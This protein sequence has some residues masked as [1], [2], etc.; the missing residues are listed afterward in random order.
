MKKFKPP[1]IEWEEIGPTQAAEYLKKNVTNRNVRKGTVTSYARD[2]KADKWIPTHQGIA[3]NDRGELIDGQHRLHAIIEAGVSVRMLVTRGI[4]SEQGDMRT[5][6]AV[7]RGAVRSVADQLHLQHGFRNAAQLAGCGTVIV[8]LTLQDRIGRVSVPQMLSVLEIYSRHIDPIILAFNNAH[9]LKMR[10]ALLC[11]SL[12][13]ARAVAPQRVDDFTQ[14]ICTGAGLEID[15]PALA[16]RNYFLTQKASSGDQRKFFALFVLNCARCFVLGEPA[17]KSNFTRAGFI[18]F[19]ERQKENLSKLAAVF[20][21]SKA[22]L[23]DD[24]GGSPAARA[25]SKTAPVAISEQSKLITADNFKLTPAAEALLQGK[26]MSDR[27]GGSRVTK[28]R[29]RI[30]RGELAGPK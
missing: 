18:Y 19:A 25:V 16:L 7:D 23:V 1:T 21:A 3:F 30:A 15:S 2:M 10:G 4:Q 11:G 27:F 8:Q 24:V 13:F 28:M 12:A 5:M 9:L 29:Q 17:R 22:S 14:S 6:D 26:E 20:G